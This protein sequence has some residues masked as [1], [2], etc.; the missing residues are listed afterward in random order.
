MQT[1]SL[2]RIHPISWQQI[3]AD[4]VTE[5]AQLLKRLQ[6]PENM[7]DSMLP[8][9]GSFSLRV[10]EPYLQRIEPGNAEDPL[11][12]Q[13]LPRPE[14]QLEIRGYVA[15]PL[16]EQNSN[17]QQGLI[18]KYRG[19][20]LLI[21][22]GGCAINCRYCFRRHFPYGDNQL[23]REQWQQVLDYLN[24]NS[25]I[26]EV[27]FSGGD[28]M[29]TTDQRLASMVADLESIPH[30]KRLRLHT[31]L[32]VVIPQRVTKELTELLGNSSLQTVV[33][34]HINHP[35]ELDSSLVNALGQLQAVTHQLLNQ[36]VLLAGINDSS[37][38]LC[39]LS[40][41]LFEAG[42]LPYYLHLLDPVAGASHFNVSE[43]VAK[44][45]VGQMCDQLPGYLVPKL[46]KELAGASAK[47]PV[48]PTLANS[49]EATT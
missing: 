33:V 35:Q 34:T 47:V 11:L 25:S 29:A 31:R 19:R 7:L 39:Q 21:V 8:G 46:V 24:Q 12:L 45:L 2:N 16:N 3:L 9:H 13:V 18:H 40:E 10:P 36:S 43:E 26:S 22:S 27:I 1:M 44:S 28:P 48:M 5:P 15:D 6:L 23:G 4:S 32:P 37:A 42:A 38:T 17:Q 30:I 49:G 41:A 20:V 14:E